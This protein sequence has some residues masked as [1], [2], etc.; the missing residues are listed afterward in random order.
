[1]RHT[2]FEELLSAYANSELPR[3]QREFVEEHLSGCADCRA[4]LADHVWVR[5]R[6]TSLQSV[7]TGADI[8][9]ATMSRIREADTRRWFANR[10]VRPALIAAA[11]VVA[12]VVPVVLQLSG[13]GVPTARAYS[14]FA[15][16]QS[17][18]MAGSTIA[19]ADRTTSQIFFEWAFVA[20]DRYQGTMT[21]DGEVQEFIIVGEEQYA[22]ASELGQSG[23]TVVVIA[24]SGFSIFNPVPGREGTLQ[25]LDSLVDL[26]ELPG[27]QIDRV[28]S[29][30][31]RGRVDIDRIIGE[32]VSGLDP[33]SPVYQGTLDFLEVHRRARIDVDIWIGEEDFSIRQM[34]LDV[35]APT[36]VSDELGTRVE[37]SAGY[38]TTVR[39]FD[40]NASIRIE[41]PVTASGVLEAGWTRSR[42]G[43]L[44]RHTTQTRKERKNGLGMDHH[45]GLGYSR[46]GADSRW[47][48]RLSWH[49]GER[50]EGSG[51]DGSCCGG[52]HVGHSRD[53]STRIDHV[54]R[55]T[56]TV[57]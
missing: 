51:G 47:R 19:T 31:Y 8:T 35:E 22:R 57:N 7:P 20:P 13:G 46:R 45:I 49:G 23:G 50:I 25:I 37:G 11:L 43:K 10:L 28:D 15:G 41:R 18:R 3:T 29:L 26:E 54:G 4:S 12:I 21:V 2:E 17:Y 42:R 52:G 33:E 44:E 39:F 5:S 27:E 48:S 40:L 53:G 36:T 30:H 24:S 16:L 56:H 38:T 1:M 34:K 9:E 32:Q 55:P 14:V 6:L